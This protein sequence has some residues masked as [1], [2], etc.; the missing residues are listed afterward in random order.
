MTR[1]EIRENKIS[2]VVV[3]YHSHGELCVGVWIVTAIHTNSNV[4]S[5]LKRREHTKRRRELEMCLSSFI[6]DSRDKQS[7]EVGI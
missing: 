2:D 4:N 5:A 3:R 1:P 7:D 6:I